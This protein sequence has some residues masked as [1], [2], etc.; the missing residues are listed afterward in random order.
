MYFFFNV[1]DPFRTE[2][3]IYVHDAHRGNRDMFIASDE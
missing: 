1:N 3:Q 2:S